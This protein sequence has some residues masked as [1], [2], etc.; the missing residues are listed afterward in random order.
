MLAID[1]IIIA[2]KDPAQAA[3]NFG[4]KHGVTTL[5][6]G[7]HS[8]WGTYNY[9]AYFSNDCYIEW[10]GIFDED[11]AKRSDI[12]LIQ[13]LVSALNN[14]IEGMIQFALRINN[15]DEHV[16]YFDV[17]SLPYTGPIPGYRQKPDGSDLH[18]RMLFPEKEL[19]FLIEWG[20]GKNIPQD[21][22]LINKQQ[23]K[24]ITYG[25]GE[26][27]FFKKTF[28]LDSANDSILLENGELNFSTDQKLNFTFY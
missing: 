23:L 27:G 2:A 14:D 20:N 10:L 4:E 28:Q 11:L 13:Q 21:N 22:S 6:G 3:Q 17:I 8:N 12:P 16:K 1:H 15:M 19:P 24:S 25:K 7:K 5:K 26:A 18:W 9:L